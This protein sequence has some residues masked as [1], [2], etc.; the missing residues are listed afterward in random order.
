MNTDSH[1]DKLRNGLLLNLES[2]INEILEG[3]GEIRS[4]LKGLRLEN[5][6]HALQLNKTEAR[7]STAIKRTNDRIN[8]HL[9]DHLENTEFMG[10]SPFVRKFGKKHWKVLFS[11]LLIAQVALAAL[12]MKYGI[13]KIIG[14][15]T[16]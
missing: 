8:L 15:F 12:L 1:N 6:Q 7:F 11:G 10:I 14:I 16:R 5:E 13:E 4:E 9:K 2:S 3:I